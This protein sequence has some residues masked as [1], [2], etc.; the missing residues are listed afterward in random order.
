MD[1][2]A[3]GLLERAGR[4]IRGRSIRGRAFARAV[5]TLVLAVAVLAGA[6]AVQSAHAQER[7]GSSSALVDGATVGVG[8]NFY[9]GDLDGNSNSELIPFLVSGNMDLMAAVHRR[10]GRGFAAGLTLSYDR[11]SGQNQEANFAADAFS[12]IAEGRYRLPL[13]PGRIGQVFVGVGPVLLFPHY[14]EFPETPAGNYRKAGTRFAVFAPV[15]VIL[16]GRV[17]LGVKISFTDYLDGFRGDMEKDRDVLSFINVG[18]RF[19]S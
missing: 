10:L 14:Y 1:R 8:L 17:R 18:Y 9:Q 12:L 6:A 19:G 11:F 13:P 15:G 7:D 3:T 4:F 2:S 5:C 16:W